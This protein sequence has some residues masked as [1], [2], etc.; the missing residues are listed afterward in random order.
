VG[1]QL[2]RLGPQTVDRSSS[3]PDP[4]VGDGR[5]PSHWGPRGTHVSQSPP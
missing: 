5:E 4:L 3:R 1:C 2:G